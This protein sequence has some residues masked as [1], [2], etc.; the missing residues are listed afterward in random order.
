[1]TKEEKKKY[2]KSFLEAGQKTMKAKFNKM[3]KEEKRKYLKAFIKA[4]HTSPSSIEKAI[5]KVLDGLKIEYQ[6][7]VS[8]NN[9]KFIVDIY[10]PTQKLIIECN[11][12]YWHNYKI[13]PSTKIRDKAL[14]NYANENSYK[15]IWLWEHNIKKNPKS[16]LIEAFEDKMVL[17]KIKKEV[18]KC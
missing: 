1:M 14:E 2:L 11:G 17:D 5:W 4:G 6:T 7:Q 18:K 9:N 12:D 10:I 15:I 13:F 8:F 3:T 16:A